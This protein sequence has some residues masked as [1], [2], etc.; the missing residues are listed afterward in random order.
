MR[1]K[2]STVLLLAAAAV[3]V[4]AGVF[5]A[6]ESGSVDSSPVVTDEVP[7]ARTATPQEIA[8]GFI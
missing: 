2:A 5:F 7:E 1:L 4:I 8:A 6:I 3:I